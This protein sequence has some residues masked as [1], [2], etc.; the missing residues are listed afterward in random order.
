MTRYNHTSV[1]QEDGNVLETGGA[2]D[3]PL[4]ESSEMSE[5]VGTSGPTISAHPTTP[6][7]DVLDSRFSRHLNEQF[8]P[9]QFPPELA[10]RVLTHASYVKA[11]TDGHNARLG[12]LGAR[13]SQL[14]F[15]SRH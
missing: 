15:L 9:L 8:P 10:R 4:A 7:E 14:L 12:F 5:A 13:Q 6:D 11:R 2:L 1:Q 3:T